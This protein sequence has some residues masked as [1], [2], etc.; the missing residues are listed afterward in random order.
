MY[1]IVKFQIK[2]VDGGESRHLRMENAPLR[3][4]SSKK[5]K[6]VTKKNTLGKPLNISQSVKSSNPVCKKF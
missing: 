6:N 1:G 5:R 3:V 2:F 4:E